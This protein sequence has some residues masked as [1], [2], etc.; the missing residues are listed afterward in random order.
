VNPLYLHVGYRE[1][2]AVQYCKIGQLAL[3]DRAHLV[4]HAKEPA[5]AASEKPKRFRACELL[6]AI[7]QQNSDYNGVAFLR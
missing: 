5:I 4:F 3:L 7:D 1:I 6:V 2:I